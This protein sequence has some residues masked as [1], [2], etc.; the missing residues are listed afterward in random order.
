MPASRACR[1]GFSLVELLVVIAIIA[2]LIGILLPALGGARD[3]AGRV[4][5]LSDLR[6]VGAARSMYANEWSGRMIAVRRLGMEQFSPVPGHSFQPLSSDW[7]AGMGSPGGELVW[8]GVLASNEGILIDHEFHER[9][10]ALFCNSP[11]EVGG[12]GRA[13]LAADAQFGAD[14]WQQPGQRV[15]YGT[16]R[17]RS[18][19]LASADYA[20]WRQLAGPGRDLHLSSDLLDDHPQ[21]SLGTC[22]IDAGRGIAG[23]AHAGR[24][25]NSVHGDGSAVWIG[26]TEDVWPTALASERLW[27]SYIDSHGNDLNRYDP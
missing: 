15:G 14:H 22:P 3:A 18:K 9:V 16:Y 13:V 1:P 11:G 4:R 23:M 21:R 5:C 8:N 12:P 19:L 7:D 25:A 27:W 10:D 24:G 2:L 6:S 26:M 20:R 17:G